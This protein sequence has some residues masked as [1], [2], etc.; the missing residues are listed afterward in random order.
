[1]LLIGTVALPTYGNTDGWANDGE[2]E[3]TLIEDVETALDNAAADRAVSKKEINVKK[4]GTTLR[5]RQNILRRKCILRRKQ[6][7]N[8]KGMDTAIAAFLLRLI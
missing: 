3:I 8:R 6:L 1:M 5:Q 2:Y 7:S 4:N